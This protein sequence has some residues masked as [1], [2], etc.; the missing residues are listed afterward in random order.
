MGVPAD[1]VLL[2]GGGGRVALGA[3]SSA[4]CCVRL[5]AWVEWGRYVSTVV[6]VVL[7]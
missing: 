1:A 3:E 5:S 2:R 6:C 7:L 4:L